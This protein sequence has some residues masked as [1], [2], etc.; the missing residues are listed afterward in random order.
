MDIAFIVI[1][2]LIILIFGYFR[3]LKE[4]RTAEKVYFILSMAVSLTVLLLK[5]LDLISFHP[6]MALTELFYRLNLM[7]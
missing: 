7:P 2:Y 6:T 5:S 3:V 4:R 1:A